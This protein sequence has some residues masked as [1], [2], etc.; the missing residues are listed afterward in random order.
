MAIDDPFEAVAKQYPNDEPKIPKSVSG[1]MGAAITV[2]ALAGVPHLAVPAAIVSAWNRLTNRDNFRNRT[3]ETQA[4]LVERVRTLEA[5]YQRLEDEQRPLTVDLE[6]LKSSIQLA[7]VNDAQTFD[8]R[9]RE[10]FI[11]AISNATISPARVSDLVSFIQDI[12]QLNEADITDR[13][14]RK[15][16]QQSPTCSRATERGHASF[17]AWMTCATRFLQRRRKGIPSAS[18]ASFRPLRSSRS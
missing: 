14:Y 1:S 10:R 6:D 11:R 8:D 17:T 18:A 4:L 3:E 5:Q 12:D 15:R 13:C 16:A 2:A 7:I 9:K